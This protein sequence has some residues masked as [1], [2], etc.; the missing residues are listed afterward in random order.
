MLMLVKTWKMVTDR[1]DE[2]H[3]CEPKDGQE[4][5]KKHSKG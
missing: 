1:H 3:S 2:H 5:K 4:I